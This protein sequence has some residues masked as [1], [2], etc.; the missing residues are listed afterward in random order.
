M[1]CLLTVLMFLGPR[2][3]LGLWWLVDMNWFSRAYES[4]IFPFVG[5][6]FLPFTTLMWSLIL[7]FDPVAGVTGWNWLWI[8][9]AVIT[10]IA[11]YS[12]GAYGNRNRIPGMSQS[13][14]QV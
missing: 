3:A 12:G 4:F 1:C 9:L 7:K 2:T 10:D 5:F 13:P 6:I 14:A 11:S 8:I